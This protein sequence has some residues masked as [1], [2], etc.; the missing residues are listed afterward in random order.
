M[1]NG[2][3]DLAQPP[4]GATLV[5]DIEA[6]KPSAET[7][8]GIYDRDGTLFALNAVDRDTVLRPLAPQAIGW[9]GAVR[10]LE[11]QP[12]TPIWPWL[13][14]AAAVLAILDGLAVLALSGRLTRRFAT[15]ASLIFA[16]MLLLPSANDAQAQDRAAQMALD[17]TT[18]TQL[19][20]VETGNAELDETS[21]AGLDGLSIY[22]AD[23]TALEPGQPAA[24]DIATDELVVLRAPLLADRSGPGDAIA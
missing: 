23:R 6:A 1:L 22:L 14:A 19:A 9:T 2:Y 21:R 11:P 4:P 16:T 18:K 17:A 3:G 15:A 12:A 8:P 24:I 7:P 5:A 13:L 10:A 20:Y